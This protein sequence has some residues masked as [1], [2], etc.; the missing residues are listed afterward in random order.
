MKYK[1][2]RKEGYEHY[3]ILG[4]IFGRTTTVRGLRNA[5]TQPPPTSDEERKLEEN[6]LN[7]GVHMHVEAEDDDGTSLRSTDDTI[8]KDRRCKKLKISKG[9]KL[10]VCMEQWINIQSDEAELKI[11][12]LKEKLARLKRSSPTLKIGPTALA[13]Y[14]QM[15]CL[16]ILN[17]MTEVTY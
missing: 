6:F 8:S 13:P 16:N 10:D 9:D 2:F 17:S 1:K 15:A 5:S 3:A 14:S 4:E 11:L 12:Y 7:K